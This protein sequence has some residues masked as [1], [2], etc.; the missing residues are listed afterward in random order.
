VVEQFGAHQWQ[1]AYGSSGTIET[2]A[3]LC[4]ELGFAPETI[5]RAGM[6]KIVERI[7]GVDPKKWEFV[8]L[9]PQRAQ[10]LAGGLAVL[11]GLFS[12]LNVEVMRPCYSALRQGVMIDLLER[13]TEHDMSTDVRYSSITRLAKRWL[14]DTGQAER[15]QKMALQFWTQAGNEDVAARD[16]LAWAALTHE[17]GMAVSHS[18]Y[19]KHGDYLMRHADLAGFSFTE[20]AHIAD[21]IAAQ[22]GGLR[23]WQAQLEDDSFI[24]AVLC[25]RLAVIVCHAR[26]DI[27]VPDVNII[28]EAEG[29]SWT[30]GQAWRMH[31]P[32]SA[33]LLDE[34]WQV[35]LK[36]GLVKP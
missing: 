17:I 33:Y 18:S 16:W 12:A 4:T 24:R 29:V 3:Q 8:D 36:A 11:M 5:T 10:V 22:R 28:I 2:I 13:L 27:D 7:V 1:L 30:V 9:K 15:V 20:Q 19:H 32:L 23:K 6:K 14:V 25:L 26:T 31:F 21:L 35:W 34:E